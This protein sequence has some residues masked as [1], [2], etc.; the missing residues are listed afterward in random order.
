MFKV[1]L[2]G[3]D[4]LWRIRFLSFLPWNFFAN[5]TK[6]KWFRVGNDLSIF[7]RLSDHERCLKTGPLI[8]TKECDIPDLELS[9]LWKYLQ[10]L[11][12]EWKRPHLYINS[13]MGVDINKKRFYRMAQ[14]I[15]APM[16]YQRTD[17]QLTSPL[18]SFSPCVLKWWKS[19]DNLDNIYVTGQK[20]RY[21]KVFR[22]L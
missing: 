16:I 18:E 14:I 12:I 9:K 13:C 3:T 11:P 15:L 4:G 2:D 22:A 1:N 6:I 10:K 7:H 21:K 20:I 19:F 5:L 8:E 17:A